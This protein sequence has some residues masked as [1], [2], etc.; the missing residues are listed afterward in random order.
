MMPDHVAKLSVAR[1]PRKRERGTTDGAGEGKPVAVGVPLIQY[2]SKV[3]SSR[4]S[5]LQKKR[6][7]RVK[8]SSQS[9]FGAIKV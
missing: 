9:L 7:K 5:Y 1:M 4:T 2:S 3:M 6:R 8:V